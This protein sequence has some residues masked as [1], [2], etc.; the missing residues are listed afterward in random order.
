MKLIY[1]TQQA[2]RV[3][4]TNSVLEV[5]DTKVGSLYSQTPHTQP[6]KMSSQLWRLLPMGGGRL[7]AFKPIMG[8]I[9]PQ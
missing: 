1:D 7:R 3:I 9:F 5:Q 2:V 4:H 6:P 8:Q